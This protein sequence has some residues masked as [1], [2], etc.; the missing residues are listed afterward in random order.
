[1]DDKKMKE[2]MIDYIDGK[3]TGELKLFVEKHINKGEHNRKSFEELKETIDL[4]QHDKEVEPDSDLKLNFLD[5]LES[6]IEQLENELENKEAKVIGLK[7][8]NYWQ[9]AAAVSILVVGLLGGY[10]LTTNSQEKEQLMALQREM[11]ATKKMVMMA[12][13]DQNSASQRMLGVN[14][15]YELKTA[16]GDIVDALIETMNTDDNVNVRLAAINALA[17]FKNE[18]S[19][20]N[21][22]IASLEKQED[23]IVQI[24]LINLMVEM[25]EKGAI[26]ELKEIIEDSTNIESVKDEAH[27]AVFKLS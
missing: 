11:E 15:S 7:I 12:L 27:M 5:T 19:I 3:L 2:L 18:P 25:K 9:V 4:L 8:S 20:R 23:P 26:E 10:W 14:A 1:M 13:N 24:T 21:A 22:L 6:E 17:N 16:D